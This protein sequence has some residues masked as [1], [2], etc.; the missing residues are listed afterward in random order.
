MTA[1]NLIIHSSRLLK[2]TTE[3]QV[4]TT[5]VV[6]RIN[7]NTQDI[8][9]NKLLNFLKSLI[10]D[11]RYPAV[12]QILENVIKHRA[13]STDCNFSFEGNWILYDEKHDEFTFGLSFS[14]QTLEDI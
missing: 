12:K 9:R 14:K 13:S 6:L 2:F 3:E 5:P 10:P 8:Q 4:I 1:Y 7:D 11:V